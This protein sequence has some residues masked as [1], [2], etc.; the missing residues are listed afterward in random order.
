MRIFRWPLFLLLFLGAV[1][2]PAQSG[3]AALLKAGRADEALRAL[4][5]TIA[6]TPNDAP[7]YNLLCRVYFQLEMWDHAM[8]MAEK[9]VALE[10]ENS[11]FHLWLARA[12]GRKAEA[13]NPFTAFGL[14]R[15]VKTEFERAVTLDPHNLPARTDLSEFYLEAP[16]FLGGDRGKARQQADFVSKYDPARASYIYARVEEKQ[17]NGGSEAE[18]K[19]A[20]SASS[21]PAHYWVELAHYY[22]RTGRLNEMEAALNQSLSVAREGDVAAFD[23]AALLLHSGRNFSGAVQMLRQYVSQPDPAEEGPAFQAHYLLGVLLEKQSRKKEA[24]VEFQAALALASQ[25]RPARDALAR[26]SR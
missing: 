19:K 14:A 18:Y 25:Y 16:G 13:S 26:V 7:S 4:N 11:L 9:S 20:V 12:M 17:G 8:R 5:A 21:A 10:P 2:A 1:C 15:R 22:R 3:P 24:A 6:Q 23:A